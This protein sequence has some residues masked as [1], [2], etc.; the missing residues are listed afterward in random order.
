MKKSFRI[1]LLLAVASIV[2]ACAGAPVQE[3]SNAR[4][5]V[6]AAQR[7]G[8]EQAAPEQYK[9]ARSLLRKAE[10]ALRTRDYDSARDNAVEA[11]SRAQDALNRAR[12]SDE[13]N[14]PH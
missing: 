11:K 6:R 5:A 1:A 2:I 7:A 4:Q 9:A 3:M 12:D 10:Q 8:A 14:D 13:D